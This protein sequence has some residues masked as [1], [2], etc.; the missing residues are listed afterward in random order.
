MLAFLA[1]DLV[2]V[3]GADDCSHLVPV[4]MTGLIALSLLHW[5]WAVWTA[6]VDNTSI[7]AGCA[8]WYFIHYFS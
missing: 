8:Y 5:V 1:D 4:L 7:R 3:L 2:V 6:K